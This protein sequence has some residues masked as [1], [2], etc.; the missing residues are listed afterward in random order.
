MKINCEEASR[1]ASQAL[2]G[3]LSW[4]QR[5]KLRFHARMCSWCEGQHREMSALRKACRSCDADVS[6]TQELS[7]AARQRILAVIREHLENEQK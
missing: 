2:E 7:P 1:L 5:I 3:P 6:P 4:W